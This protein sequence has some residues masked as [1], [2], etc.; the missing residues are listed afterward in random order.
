MNEKIY[1]PAPKQRESSPKT[2]APPPRRKL[3]RLQS[4]GIRAALNWLQAKPM[5]NY[6]G[7]AYEQEADRVADQITSPLTSEDGYNHY[8]QRHITLQRRAL[9]D[10]ALATVPPSVQKTVSRQ[11]RPLQAP[12]RAI[13]EPYFRRDFANVQVHKGS[14]AEASAADV[15]A[16]AYTVGEHVVFGRGQYDPSSTAG[17]RLIAHELT[18]VVQ[19]AEGETPTVQRQPSYYT[20]VLPQ[21]PPPEVT[22]DRTYGSYGRGYKVVQEWPDGSTIVLSPQGDYYYFPAGAD[23]ATL[24]WDSDGYFWRPLT[25]EGQVEDVGPGEVITI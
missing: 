18:H 13:M 24:L 23:H 22:G 8:R 21:I 12:I 14:Q 15:N 20:P 19:Q 11:G 5:V 17:Q 16:L 3:N 4:N 25:A 1:A 10:H 7:D 2:T 6:P 9:A